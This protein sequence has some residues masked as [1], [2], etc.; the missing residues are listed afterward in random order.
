VA[1]FPAH[2]PE[3]RAPD[4]VRFLEHPPASRTLMWPHFRNMLLLSYMVKFPVLGPAKRAPDA[5]RFPTHVLARRAP[6]DG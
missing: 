6:A 3:Q 5:A 2:A 1:R 4:V